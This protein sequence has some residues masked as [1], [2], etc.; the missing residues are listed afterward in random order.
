MR[1]RDRLVA[2]RREQ[3]LLDRAILRPADVHA[4]VQ[5][6]GIRHLR[7]PRAPRDDLRDRGALLGQRRA[8]VVEHGGARERQPHRDSVRRLDEVIRELAA[9]LRL[10]AVA[11]VVVDA[12]A[13]LRGQE[14]AGARGGARERHALAAHQ[15]NAERCEFL[16]GAERGIVRDPVDVLQGRMRGGVDADE[17]VA[18]AA[19]TAALTREHDAIGKQERSRHHR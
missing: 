18:P 11:E 13:V 5:R 1:K 17:P 19:V 15:R 7:H 4:G 10:G 12:A 8:A 3:R 2:E 14:D 16:A 6:D 9:H